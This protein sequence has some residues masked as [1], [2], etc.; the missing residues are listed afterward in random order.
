MDKFWGLSEKG[1]TVKI[2]VMAG[3]TTFVT[4]AYIFVVNP[5]LLSSTA[6][7][8]YYNPIFIATCLSAFVGTL[9]MGLYARIPFAQASG[10]G[11]NAFCAFTVI[12]ALGYNGAMAVVFISGCLFLL[13]SFLGA[14]EAIVNAIPHTIKIANS[15]GIG[16]YIAFIGMQNAGV[17]INHESTLVGFASFRIGQA[18]MG[19]LLALIGVFIIS[20]LYERRVKGSVLLGIL[21][22][23][24]LGIP[25]GVTKLPETMQLFAVPD[26][27]E[28]FTW[29]LFKMDFSALFGTGAVSWEQISNFLVMMLAFTMVDMFDTIGC[30]V[31]TAQKAGL[32]DKE[33]RF[34]QMKKAL[35]CDAA[36]TAAGACCG[37]S[38]VTTYIES[39]AGITAG[40]KTGLTSVVTAVLMLLT[41]FFLPLIQIIPSAAT[42][43]ALI[44]V[45]IQMLGNIKSLEFEDISELVPA[46]MTIVMIPFTYSV[47]TGIGIGMITYTVLKIFSGKWREIPAVTGIIAVLFLIRFALVV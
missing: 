16:L 3:I 45:G 10:M 47:A 41:L 6:G 24:L 37:T 2:E 23:A 1:T 17:I 33:G 11:L 4:M 9:L 19:A 12:P 20:I 31:G 15:V 38:T 46:F 42:A 27:K 30:L 35:I 22:T 18:D 32:L 26:F 40:G 29:S 25:M 14:R 13:L 28:F 36:A 44:F 5:S 8:Q 21:L 34:P 43:P 39:G 7:G